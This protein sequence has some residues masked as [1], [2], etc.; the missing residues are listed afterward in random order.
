M[1]VL[2]SGDPHCVRDD[3]RSLL[4]GDVRHRDDRDLDLEQNKI[5]SSKEKSFQMRI[6]P[7]T[8][9]VAVLGQFSAGL[10]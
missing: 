10:E 4:L 6:S 5:I 9:L 7:E 3:L 8:G 1:L 2:E